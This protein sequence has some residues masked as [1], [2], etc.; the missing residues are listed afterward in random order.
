ME[1]KRVW[2][3]MNDELTVR[4]GADGDRLPYVLEPTGPTL[5]LLEQL[6]SRCCAQMDPQSDWPPPQDLECMAVASLNLLYLQL[7]VSN[8]ADL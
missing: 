1:K 3:I 2:S 5:A 7:Q 8:A 6:L 4:V